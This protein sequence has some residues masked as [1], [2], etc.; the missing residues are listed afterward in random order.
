MGICCSYCFILNL[1]CNKN[2]SFCWIFR[3]MTSLKNLKSTHQQLHINSDCRF[4]RKKEA[5]WRLTLDFMSRGQL[6]NIKH[7]SITRHNHTWV[8]RRGEGC[9]CTHRYYPRVN[10]AVLCT[11]TSV[12]LKCQLSLH[13]VKLTVYCPEKTWVH[14]IHSKQFNLS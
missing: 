14:N 4:M 13:D 3:S 12:I 9:S 7:T 8:R 2:F 6:E 11:N 10:R 5:L 1:K